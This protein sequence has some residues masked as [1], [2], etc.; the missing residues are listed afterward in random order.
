M[1]P[2]EEACMDSNMSPAPF[3]L[4]RPLPPAIGSALRASIERFGVLVP[5]V[6]DQHGNVLDGHQRVRIADE[7]GLKYPVNVIEVADEAEA[8]EIARTL[9]EDRRAMPKVERLPV[10]V[11]LREEGH[12]LRAIAGVV[13]V[14]VGTVHEDLSGVQPRTPEAVTGRD[15]KSYPARKEPKPPPADAIRYA[16]EAKRELRQ[17]RER[18]RIEQRAE[19]L[20][21]EHPLDG[22]RYRVFVH[23]IRDG[24]P[25]IVPQ[26]IITDPP[27]PAEYCPLFVN[28]AS[29]AAIMLPRSGSLLAMSGQANLATVYRTVME[30]E[31]V[32]SGELIYQWTLAYLTPGQSTQVFSRCVKSNWKPILWYTNGAY[33]GEHVEDTIRSGENDKR[34][35]DWG[36]SVSGMVALI[37]R[38]TVPGDLVYDPFCGGGATGVAALLTGRLFVGSDIDEACV[39]QTAARLA[40]VKP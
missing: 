27:Y 22:E 5:V 20:A 2:D 19:V 17:E 33:T 1:K 31:A 15:G 18:Q 11:A 26:A 32:S 12:S 4:F 3:Q 36:Q 39:K 21:T 14:S 13:G 8:L 7:L 37:E 38:F 29:Y 28:L 16:K 30:S 6:R 24:A 35:H 34:F 25:D 23:D 40:E 10:E 9:N